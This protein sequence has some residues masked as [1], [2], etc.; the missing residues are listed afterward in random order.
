M[1]RFQKSINSLFSPSSLAVIGAS[2]DPKKVG[3]AILNNLIKSGYKGK[4]YIVN[5]NADEAQ[6]IKSYK[7]IKL[8]KSKADLAIIIVPAQFAAESLRECGEAGIKAA[9]VISSGFKEN[10]E[11]GRKREEALK[12]IAQEYNIALVGPNCLGIINTSNNLNASFA[13]SYPQDGKVALV[14]QSGAIISSLIDW[15]NQNNLGFSNI[16]SLGNKAVLD[17]TDILEYLEKDKTVQVI[18]LYLENI[19]RAEK[20]VNIARKIASKK[21][22]V[23]FKSG[24]SKAGQDAS[25]SHTG[26][27]ATED[28]LTDA[29]IRKSGAIRAGSLSEFLETLRLFNFRK[30]ISNEVFVIS[31]A[32]GLAVA[33]ADKIELSQNLKFVKLNPE[34]MKKLR[35]ILP[36]FLPIKNPLDIGGDANSGRYE[37]VLINLLCGGKDAYSSGLL[38]RKAA[39]TEKHSPDK[40]NTFTT[41]AILTPQTMTDSENAADLIADLNEKMTI[42]PVFSGGEKLEKSRKIFKEAG[43]PFYDFPEDAIKILDIAAQQNNFNYAFAESENFQTLQRDTFYK[44]K[45]ILN[46]SSKEW[47]SSDKTLEIAKALDIPIAKSFACNDINELNRIAEKIIY[48]V[49][50]KTAVGSIIHKAKQK[51]VIGDIQNKKDLIAAFMKV[52]KPAIIQNQEKK[53]LELIIGARREEGTG[54]FIMFGF[55]GIFASELGQVKFHMLPLPKKEIAQIVGDLPADNLISKETKGKLAEIILSLQRLII[56]FEA[57]KD[58]DLN[59]VMINIE[60]DKVIC[61]DVKIRVK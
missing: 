47:V 34:I 36:P 11:E 57:I 32:G 48:P 58:V 14:S 52:Q 26:A 42:I 21:P 38:A 17:E 6:G 18:G 24:I 20:F 50:V 15:G 25:Q 54:E 37:K 53:N 30:K 9:I 23:I 60:D 55:G 28:R 10:G 16:I 7:T 59:P 8:I 40:K 12:K 33:S 49:F 39:I 35:I 5:P 45:T 22:I 27:L 3:G 56:N 13:S 2:R 51:Q 41:I 46:N 1:S 44:I 4:I 43:I 61:P 19:S 29:I 31:N